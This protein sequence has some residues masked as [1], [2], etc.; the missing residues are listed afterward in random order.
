MRCLFA[1]LVNTGHLHGL[2]HPRAHFRLGHPQIFQRK[3]HVLFHHRRDDLVVGVL[4]HHAHPLAD[5]VQM[6]FVFGV[7]LFYKHLTLFGQ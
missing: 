3:G 1:V 2:I 5:V 7:V 6:F 4:K